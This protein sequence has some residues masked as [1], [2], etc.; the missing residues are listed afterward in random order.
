MDEGPFKRTATSELDL[1]AGVG[2]SGMTISSYGNRKVDVGDDMTSC[3]FEFE[4]S[5]HE[6]DLGILGM[7]S[8]FEVDLD[9]RRLVEIFRQSL[10]S[11][12]ER[13][14]LKIF[15]SGS[16]IGPGAAI[17]TLSSGN[18]KRG[19]GFGRAVIEA[20]RGMFGELHNGSFD[21]KGPRAFE[22]D[23]P[24]SLLDLCTPRRNL[25]GDTCSV[26]VR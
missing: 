12:N 15:F 10:L 16:T 4:T 5:T 2:T 7:F 9:L 21:K 3:R 25:D 11:D 23:C 8:V 22:N 20:G 6:T 17:S 19:V 18:D 13:D 24:A 14:G 26:G 1:G